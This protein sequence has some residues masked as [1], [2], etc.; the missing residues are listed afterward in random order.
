MLWQHVCRKQWKQGSVVIYE[1]CTDC[2][3]KSVSLMSLA[4]FFNNNTLIN[5]TS[6]YTKINKTDSTN[7]SHRSFTTCTVWLKPEAA[8]TQCK[9]GKLKGCSRQTSRICDIDY[10]LFNA[11]LLWLA[12]L[13]IKKAMT[14]GDKEWNNRILTAPSETSIFLCNYFYYFFLAKAIIRCPLKSA[15][16]RGL[17]ENFKQLLSV[18]WRMWPHLQVWNQSVTIRILKKML[19]AS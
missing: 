19:K 18:R 5:E 10:L 12:F 8:L 4:L 6:I 17:N 3:R 9:Q 14:G 2:T 11:S 16:R 13:P 1:D 15:V 7:T